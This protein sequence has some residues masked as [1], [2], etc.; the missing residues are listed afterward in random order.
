[1]LLF[2]RVSGEMDWEVE[3]GMSKRYLGIRFGG[4]GV[5]FFKKGDAKRLLF[6]LDLFSLLL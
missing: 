5:F 4:G 2:G 1:L 6:E 3:P